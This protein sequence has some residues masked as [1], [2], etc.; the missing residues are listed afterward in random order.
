MRSFPEKCGKLSDRRDKY[1]VLKYVSINKKAVPERYR[2]L[3]LKIQTAV[4]QAVVTVLELAAEQVEMVE[5]AGVFRPDNL[6][7]LVL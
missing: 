2:F 3:N 4:F 7:R 1:P 5:Q 6:Y